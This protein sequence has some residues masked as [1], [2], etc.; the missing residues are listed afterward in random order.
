LFPLL[1]LTKGGATREIAD[2]MLNE[3][4][5]AGQNE[6]LA[7]G[8]T[9]ASLRFNRDNIDDLPWLLRRLRDMHSILR[10]SPYY[11]E[12]LQEGREEGREEGLEKGKLEG[13]RQAVLDVVQE[14][15]PKVTRLAKKQVTFIE[16]PQLLRRLVVQMS[17]AQSKEEAKQYLLAADED[18]EE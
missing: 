5:T 1:P 15:F 6:L 7:I 9:L 2:R 8:G 16:D 17:I 18:E 12:I 3:L 4:E 11:Q 14:R 13:L 10:D